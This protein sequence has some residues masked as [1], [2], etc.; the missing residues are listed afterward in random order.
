MKPHT[1]DDLSYRKCTLEFFLFL[2]KYKKKL[3]VIQWCTSDYFFQ[4]TV[5]LGYLANRSQCIFRLANTFND[6]FALY[7][8]PN[9]SETE[10]TCIQCLGYFHWLRRNIFLHYD[11]D[12]L[13]S[14]SINYYNW[15]FKLWSENQKCY[16]PEFQMA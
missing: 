2:S 8:D 10:F 13:H 14:N 9:I 6:F 11:T 1:F 7:W 12:F 3:C 16:V 5:C 4:Y 15:L